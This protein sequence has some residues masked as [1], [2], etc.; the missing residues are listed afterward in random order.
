MDNTQ[1]RMYTSQL[2][3]ICLKR[4]EA[5]TRFNEETADEFGE[6]AHSVLRSAKVHS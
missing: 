4:I 6:E 2:W 5:L 3:V 1:A